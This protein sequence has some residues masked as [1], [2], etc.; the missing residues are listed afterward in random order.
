M[1]QWVRVLAVQIRELGFKS[2]GPK[3][4]ARYSCNGSVRRKRE[5]E[6]D[7]GNSLVSCPSQDVFLWSLHVCTSIYTCSDTWVYT[8][9]SIHTQTH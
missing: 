2:S 8:N 9:P 7:S 3:S 4:K 6:V 1:A 5:R